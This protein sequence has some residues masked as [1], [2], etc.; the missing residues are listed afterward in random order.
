MKE[1]PESLRKQAADLR[2]RAAY[3]DTR[4]AAAPDLKEARE[5]E[6]RAK[7]LD[8]QRGEK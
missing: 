4:Q 3:A 5:L 1:T 7:Q 2:E 6:D 8:K